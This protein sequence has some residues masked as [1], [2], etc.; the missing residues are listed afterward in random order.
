MNSSTPY[1]QID[2]ELEKQ[3]FLTDAGE[4]N[5]GLYSLVWELGHY[6][7]LSIGEKYTLAKDLLK[8][9]VRDGLLVVEEYEDS[10][11][12]TKLRT[13]AQEDLDMVL[14]V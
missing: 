9:L 7:A 4:G 1:D 10:E 13:V 5:Y 12:K 2:R 14:M 3:V 11:L 6:T 8:E